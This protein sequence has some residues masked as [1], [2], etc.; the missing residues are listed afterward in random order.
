M[1]M[2]QVMGLVFFLMFMKGHNQYQKL[3]I[4]KIK[5]GMILSN[6]P[7]YYTKKIILVF[8]LKI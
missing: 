7:G 1:L 3:I 5:E 8:V 6:E 2:V 4:V